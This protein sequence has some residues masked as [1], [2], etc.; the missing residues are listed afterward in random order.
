MSHDINIAETTVIAI[1]VIY[2]R[3]IGLGY[4]SDSV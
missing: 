4:P 2:I 1:S 3:V